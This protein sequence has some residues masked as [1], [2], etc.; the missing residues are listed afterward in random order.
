MKKKRPKLKVIKGKGKSYSKPV[1]ELEDDMRLKELGG[2]LM[3][4]ILTIIEER[5]SVEQQKIIMSEIEL[6]AEKDWDNIEV[7]KDFIGSVFDVIR[8]NSPTLK[9]GD[10]IVMEMLYRQNPGK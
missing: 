10:K 3:S 6:L 7:G 4:N 1:N 8:Q 9:E 5:F 2:G